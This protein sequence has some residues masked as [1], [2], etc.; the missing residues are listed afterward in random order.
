LYQ[1]TKAKNWANRFSGSFQSDLSGL[2][3]VGAEVGHDAEQLFKDASSDLAESLTATVIL[4]ASDVFMFK[5][6]SM[7]ED[8]D[9]F[10]T[11]CY[12]MPISGQI[13]THAS[14]DIS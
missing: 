3:R 7:D 1:A 6:M 10:T 13:T 2:Q 8:F 5:G 11:I 9:V 4:P 12:D 14:K